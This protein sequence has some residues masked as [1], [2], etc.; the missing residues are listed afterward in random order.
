MKT[1][2]SIFSAFLFSILFSFGFFTSCSSSDD[3]LLE[4]SPIVDPPPGDDDDDDD[5]DDPKPNPPAPW[6][7]PKLISLWNHTVDLNI[8]NV[9]KELNSNLVWT[10]DS[11]YAGQAWEK[12]HMYKCLQVPGIEYVFGKINRVAWGWTHK[13]SV[14]HARWVAGLAKEHAKIA[15]LYLNDFYDEIEE[16]YRTED[17]WREIIA[18]AKEV[19]PNLHIWAPHYP[20]RNQGQHAF[21]FDID[22][23][24]INLWGNKPEQLQDLENQIAASLERHPNR[25]VVGGLYLFSGTGANERWLTESEFKSILGHYVD[26]MNQD[27]LVGVRLFSAELFI[28]RPEYIT[29]AKEILERLEKPSDP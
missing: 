16:G 26:L 10:N 6:P 2:L 4:E 12:T 25:Y 3:P 18:A 21:D 5:E 22:G 11:P 15:G 27:K 9:V 14:E 29:W 20:H 8:T 1:T 24:I 19:N 17:Q 23:V 7:Y 28:E 13:G